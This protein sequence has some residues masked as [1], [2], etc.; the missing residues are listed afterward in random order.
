MYDT[1]D[2]QRVVEEMEKKYD[3]LYELGYSVHL[4]NVYERVRNTVYYLAVE[5]LEEFVIKNLDKTLDQFADMAFK[6]Y[7]KGTRD[8]VAFYNRYLKP[9]D[10]FVNGKEVDVTKISEALKG[11][12]VESPEDIARLLVTFRPKEIVDK[13]KD[14]TEDAYRYMQPVLRTE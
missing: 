13:I 10:E 1:N 2:L 5:M 11:I 9:L 14:M 6:D 7:E 4:K 12:G 3:E 8:S